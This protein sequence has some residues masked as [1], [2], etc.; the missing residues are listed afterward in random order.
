MRRVWFLW[1]IKIGDIL[2]VY[3][4]HLQMFVKRKNMT[5]IY[6][7]QVEKKL[8]RKPYPSIHIKGKILEDNDPDTFLF[9]NSLYGDTLP[10]FRGIWKW[11][12]LNKDERIM[13]ML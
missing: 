5:L 12:K 11:Y 4:T 13:E 9:G 7:I 6:K 3:D 2:F 1:Q 10:F 8:K